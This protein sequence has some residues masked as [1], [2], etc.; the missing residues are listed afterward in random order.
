MCGII[1]YMPL[2]SGVDDNR[3]VFARL[4]DESRIRGH[5]AYGIAQPTL[6]SGYNVLRSFN[7]VDIPLYF[8]VHFPMIAH[9]RYSQSGDW[10]NMGNNQP[11]VAAGMALAHNGVIHMGTK[12]EFERDFDVHCT[13]D[14]DSEVF[15]RQM[16]KGMDPQEFISTMT[17]SFAGTWLKNGYVYAARNARRPLWKCEAYSAL[18]YAS[19]KDIFT[20]AGFEGMEEIPVNEVQGPPSRNGNVLHWTKVY[21]A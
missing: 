8:D 11:I 14:N 13:A 6:T 7:H 16:E 12:A 10:R 1:G 20:R 5:H 3:S 18:W 19:T 9:A 2:R 15:L 4:F 21:S 17:G